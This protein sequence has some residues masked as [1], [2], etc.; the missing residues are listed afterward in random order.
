MTGDLADQ[1]FWHAQLE[2]HGQEVLPDPMAWAELKWW[3]APYLP[4]SW[5]T[6]VV[7]PVWRGSKI[8]GMNHLDPSS[9]F[10]RS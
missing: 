1:L 7:F 9:R 4:T 5:V 3:I 10:T 8:K 6:S 2:Q